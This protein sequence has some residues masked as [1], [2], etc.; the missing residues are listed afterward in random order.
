MNAM[1]Q[2]LLFDG[3]SCVADSPLAFVEAMKG[4]ARFF[5]RSKTVGEYMAGVA[6]RLG[7]LHDANE[8]DSLVYP[9]IDSSSP[10]SFVKALRDYNLLVVSELD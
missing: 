8:L 1:K 6:M 5:R 2:Y 3:F 7:T 4:S 10:E 9:T